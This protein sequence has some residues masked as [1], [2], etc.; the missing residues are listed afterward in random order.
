MYRRE[1]SRALSIYNRTAYNLQPT[2]NNYWP[3][4]TVDMPRALTS[5]KKRHIL[6]QR[7]S[8]GNRATT[9]LQV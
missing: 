7:F 9:G 3:K 5:S 2:R 4:L 8:S 6:G 1:V